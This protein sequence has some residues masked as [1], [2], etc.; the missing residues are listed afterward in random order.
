MTNDPETLLAWVHAE[1]LEAVARTVGC[2]R[3]AIARYTG[4]M[5]VRGVTRSLIERA[6]AEHLR[7][8]KEPDAKP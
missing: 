8:Q 1:T 6:L 4:R 2:G 3:E 5:P 7:T